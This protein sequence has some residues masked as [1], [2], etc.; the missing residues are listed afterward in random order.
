[1]GALI[2]EHIIELI[3]LPVLDNLVVLRVGNGGF[4]FELWAQSRPH[5]TVHPDAA[6]H[7]FKLK[8]HALPLYRC[9]LV[10]LVETEVLALCADL[11]ELKPL[12]DIF[13]S[14]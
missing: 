11:I 10:F 4:G 12:E 7:L 6:F 13:F 14:P 2:A 1:L 8:H 5:P 9:S 3:V